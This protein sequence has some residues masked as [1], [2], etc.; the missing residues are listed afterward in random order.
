MTTS[1][2][3]E[4][5][6]CER[7]VKEYKGLRVNQGVTPPKNVIPFATIYCDDEHPLGIPKTKC[8]KEQCFVSISFL[9]AA[10]CEYWE[11]KE[12]PGEL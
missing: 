6:L 8:G 9:I 12:I 7:C 10:H 4:F 11:Y 2:N 1:H 3:P 5:S